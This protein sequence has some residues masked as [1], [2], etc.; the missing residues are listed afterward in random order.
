MPMSKDNDSGVKTLGVVRNRDEN[1][2]AHWKDIFDP[3]DDGKHL[4]STQKNGIRMSKGEL[5]TN[6]GRAQ[7]LFDSFLLWTIQKQSDENQKHQ[8]M[9]RHLEVWQ[10]LAFRAL[11]YDKRATVQRWGATQLE[12]IA[13]AII[14]N[15][16]ALFEKLQSDPETRKLTSHPIYRHE[17]VDWAHLIDILQ[18]MEKD[19]TRLSLSNM[20]EK[21]NRFAPL[22]NFVVWLERDRVVDAFLLNASGDE[23][24]VKATE[25]FYQ[26]LGR[27]DR[28][29][30]GVTSLQR[31]VERML[32]NADVKRISSSCLVFSKTSSSLLLSLLDQDEHKISGDEKVKELNILNASKMLGL[33]TAAISAK[34]IDERRALLDCI[35]ILSPSCTSDVSTEFLCAICNV[36][37]ENVDI[38]VELLN[39]FRS[40]PP[41]VDVV[42]DV[43]SRSARTS[44]SLSLSLSLSLHTAHTHTLSS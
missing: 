42:V 7:R 13:Q 25:P 3:Q 17:G 24:V 30:S 38:V 14:D 40:R 16:I 4:T 34:R 10:H 41:Y 29:V 23:Y 27:L 26:K 43:D 44:T 15:L 33:W 1:E 20:I 21:Q 31:C 22:I 28:L 9:I 8:L 35:A 18:C 5:Q 39:S 6:Q 37:S 2:Y 12:K 36:V 11:K 32:S 19:D